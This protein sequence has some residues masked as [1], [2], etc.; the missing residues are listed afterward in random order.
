MSEAALR[1]GQASKEL[2][3]T[4]HH[5]RRLCASNLVEAETSPGGQYRIPLLEIERLKRSGVPPIPILIEEAPIGNESKPSPSA[6]GPQADA[7]H[8]NNSDADSGSVWRGITRQ[9][10]SVVGRITSSI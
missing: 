3:V 5:L 8:G 9:R 6:A 2:G 10:P 4:A 1:I 7:D